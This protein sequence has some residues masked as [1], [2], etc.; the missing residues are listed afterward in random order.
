VDRGGNQWL[1]LAADRL[2]AGGAA[3]RVILESTAK[4]AQT[5]RPVLGYYSF[6]SNDSAYRVRHPGLTF[7]PG[8]IGGTFVSTDGRTF[9]EPPADWIPGPSQRPPGQ[10]GNG[11]QS[12]AGDL[13]RAGLSGVSA[14]VDEPYLDATVR[15]Q[16]LFPAYLAGFNLA[17]AFYLAMPYLSWQTMIIGDPL[18]APFENKERVNE[19]TAALDPATELPATFSQRR[20]ATLARG[21]RNVEAIKLTLKA[22]VHLQRG[23]RSSAEA[24]LSQAV[25]IDP[26]L[27]GTLFQ[28]AV[29]NEGRKEYDRAIARYREVIAIEPNHVLALNNLAY[30]LAV[31]QNRPTEALPLAERAFRGAPIAAVADT[32]GW[33]H[34]LLGN[35]P[36]ARPFFEQ[37]VKSPGV[38]VEALIHAAT[39]FVGVKDF[40]R[41]RTALE[42]AERLDATINERPDVKAVRSAIK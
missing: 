4:L 41:A 37:I 10:F 1:E 15:P 17:E 5:D 13:I 18:C 42:S 39:V 40:G 14:H 31:N 28:L 20:V 7:V 36:A 30:S 11:S 26:A 6:G 12:V 33:I 25:Q 21:G 16:I 24:M 19:P 8:A 34:H 32:L 3:D 9:L 29:F 23:D 22:D 35:D 38:S 27:T 2:R